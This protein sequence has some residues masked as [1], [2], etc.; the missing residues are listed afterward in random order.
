MLVKC[1]GHLEHQSD[2]LWEI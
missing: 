1:F 2:K